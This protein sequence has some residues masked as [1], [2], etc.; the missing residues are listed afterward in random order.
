MQSSPTSRPLGVTIIAI[1]Q[2]IGGAFMLIFG[3][4]L[5]TLGAFLPTLPPSA[6]NQTDI[7]GNLTAAQIPIPPPSSDSPMAVQSFLGGLG[8]AFGAVLVAIAVVSFVVAYGLLKG[9]GWAWTVSI[10]L[11]IIS[12]VWNAITLITAANYGGIIS[13]IISGIIIYYLFRPH[14]K[15]Y[16]GKGVNPS[17]PTT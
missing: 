8:I 3:I 4:G 9:K 11:S 14:V 10:I 6:F 2:I 15:A 7:Q 13:I 5:I 16:F 17:R 12:I 1:L